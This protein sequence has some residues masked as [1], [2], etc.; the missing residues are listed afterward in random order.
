VYSAINFV[1]FLT[2]NMRAKSDPDY[3]QLLSDLRWDRLTDSQLATLNSRVEISA[4]S[5]PTGAENFH[6]PV[7]VSTNAL[8]AVIN[9]DMTFKTAKRLELPIYE[10]LAIP[11]ERSK[12]IINHI[13]DL[14]DDQTERIPIRLLFF[15]GM[16]VMIT[17][18]HPDLLEADVIANGVLG[19]VV[20]FSPEEDSSLFTTTRIGETVVHTFKRQPKLLLVKI[21]SSVAQLVKGF[22]VG[23]IGVPPLR[24][25]I[26]I[27][28]IPHLSQASLTIQQF[29]VVPAFACTTEKLQ[30]QTCIHGII[31]TPLDRRKGVPRQ[32]LYE[33]LSRS[34]SLLGVTLTEPI[35][36]KY[37][38]MFKPTQAVVSEMS[39]L[40]HF[41]VV[42]PYISL[43]QVCEFEQWKKKQSMG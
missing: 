12:P 38:A 2:E 41:I 36:R 31:V 21:H 35:T 42:P 6:R 4:S 19:T 7:V 8:R 1:V 43:D 3:T 20:G 13:I 17:R 37:L 10:C 9:R 23:V 24:A 27:P 22:P 30:G 34:V 18:K 40:I 39:R 15:I 32:T 11:S 5:G 26:K 25:P 14:N 29:A 28:R 33:A 16:P